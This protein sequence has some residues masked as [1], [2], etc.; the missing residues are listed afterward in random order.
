[1]LNRFLIGLFCFAFLGL[2]AQTFSSQD[3]A[4]VENVQAG[5]K[6]LNAQAY[7]EC[8][9]Y[10]KK[11]FA[12]KQTSY[13]S[14]LR[15]AACAFSAGKTALLS[16]YLDQA[17]E[18]SWDGSKS[19]FESYPEF[20]YLQ[21]SD[22]AKMIQERYQKAAQA[23]GLDLDL[24]AELTEIQ[25]TDQLQR[26]KMNEVSEMYGWRSPQMDSLW[27]LQSYSDS[28]NTKRIT[29][30]IDEI[31]Y[32]GRSIVGENLASTSFLVIQHASQEVQ[33]K[34]LDIITA[35]ADAGEVRWSSVALLVD[36]VRL[37]RGEKQIYG[38]QVFRDQETD[39]YYFGPIENPMKVDSIRS[40]VG[41]GPLQGYA[42]NWNFQ[43][44]PK[45]HMERVSK[46]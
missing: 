42:D 44:D 39:E 4:Y 9:D 36:R 34:Y 23:S 15:A 22:F 28:V 38:S 27:T 26:S 13:L 40:T 2:N 29:E 43:W 33:E 32:P 10:Y 18:I 7:E 37:R 46:K 19:I 12:V 1:M 31:G 16:T 11:A 35:A 24:M 45:K 6:A 25:R 14:T 20:E 8:L 30:L 5:E 41:L 21:G 17:F 3:P